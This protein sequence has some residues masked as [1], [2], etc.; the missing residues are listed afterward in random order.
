M[1]ELDTQSITFGLQVIWRLLCWTERAGEVLISG[2]GYYSIPNPLPN[3]SKV[4][5]SFGQYISTAWHVAGWLGGREEPGQYF[6]MASHHCCIPISWQC[7]TFLLHLTRHNTTQG[8]WLLAGCLFPWNEQTEQQLRSNQQPGIILAEI[9]NC[10]TITIIVVFSRVSAVLGIFR[11]SLDVFWAI[12][13]QLQCSI[14]NSI[15]SLSLC[16]SPYAMRFFPTTSNQAKLTGYPPLLCVAKHTTVPNN[17]KATRDRTALHFVIHR[18]HRT[19]RAF[20]GWLSFLL[21]NNRTEQNRAQKEALWWPQPLWNM[22]IG[23]CRRRF[24][25][26]SRAHSN[27]PSTQRILLHQ[28]LEHTSNRRIPQLKLR[29]SSVGEHANDR[30][31]LASLEQ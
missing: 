25:S 13:T 3:Q 21:S 10:C 5:I 22:H 7:A 28:F 29:Q 8:R 19:T 12:A 16:L 2:R 14:N 30:I 31:F 23:F 9:P 11:M 18:V 15:L 1:E 20:P 4:L 27:I 17:N 24:F 6:N 26:P